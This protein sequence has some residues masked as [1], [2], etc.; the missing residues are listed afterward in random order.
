MLTR[1][2]VCV[3]DLKH[4]S[5]Q[6]ITMNPTPDKSNVVS[7]KKSHCLMCCCLFGRARLSK[8]CDFI[9]FS[10]GCYSS[11]GLCG[12]VCCLPKLAHQLYNVKFDMLRLCL[13]IIMSQCQIFDEFGISTDCLY[14]VFNHLFA[15]LKIFHLVDL[16]TS[17]Y[18][19]YF[20][21]LHIFSSFTAVVV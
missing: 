15:Y 2:Y 21:C 16:R 18:L 9:N 12:C 4:H 13:P 6:Q 19:G 10:D 3:F 20:F 8:K 7:S 14:K 11:C 5:F 17:L 1:C